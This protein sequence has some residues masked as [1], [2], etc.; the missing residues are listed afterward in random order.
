MRQPCATSVFFTVPDDF[1]L[2]PTEPWEIELLVQRATGAREK[3][4]LRFDLP[5]TLPDRY[6]RH[7]HKPPLIATHNTA[8][9]KSEPAIAASSNAGASAVAASEDE[10]LWKQMWR[11]NTASIVITAL[12]IALL[13]VI[14]FFQNALV[15]RPLFYTWV[16]RGFLT[17]TLVWLGWYAKAQLSVVNVLTFS[18][19]L[20]TDFSWSYF[21]MDPLVFILWSRGHLAVVLGPG[22]FC[23]WLC[24][25]GALQELTN[26]A[27]GVR[28]AATARPLGP[29]R[30]PVAA[31][32]RHLP[33]P[34]RPLALFAGRGRAAIRGRAIQDRDRPG[35]RAGRSSSLLRRC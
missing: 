20:V 19:A 6:I 29:Q 24:P 1:A 16:R 18:N 31:E 8:G 32:I 11:R 12:A 14:F 25:F 10:P 33:C 2:D 21:L 13:T 3:A 7:E 28:R 15:R 22:P 4:F 23:G 26:S 5:Y 9:S 17:F 27:A 34:V 30:A 35:S